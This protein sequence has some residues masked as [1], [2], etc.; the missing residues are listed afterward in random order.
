MLG[1]DRLRYLTC[2]LCAAEW[3]LTRVMCATCRTTGGISYFSLEGDAG[4][5]KAEACQQ[6]RTYLKLFYLEKGPRAEA[7]ADDVATL[8]LDLLMSEEGYARGGVNLFL[9]PGAVP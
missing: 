9:L 7:F 2:S 1:D 6:C 3:H 5:V 4:A 8:S